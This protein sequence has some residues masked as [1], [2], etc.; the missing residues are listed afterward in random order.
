MR[1]TLVWSDDKA[2]A[3]ERGSRAVGEQTGEELLRC[4][5]LA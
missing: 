4:R 5:I 1:N 3:I 2:G